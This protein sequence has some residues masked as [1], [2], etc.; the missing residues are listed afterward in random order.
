MKMETQ[1][2]LSST[3]LIILVLVG[4]LLAFPAVFAGQTNP[5]QIGLSVGLG[6]I[7]SATVALVRWAILP[8]TQKHT[9]IDGNKQIYQAF[10][11]VLSAHHGDNEPHEIFTI[12]SF[13]PEPEVGRSYDEFLTHWLG[14]NPRSR[15]VRAI[16]SQR[17]S[18]WERRFAEIESRYHRSNYHEF[19]YQGPPTVEMFLFDTETVI[20]S[21]ASQEAHEPPVS[22]ALVMKD[23]QFQRL[24]QAYHR[25]H[26]QREENRTRPSKAA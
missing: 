21:F 22:S 6:I 13:P 18:A 26:L 2:A 20:L 5:Q 19:R 17:S 11:K 4:V 14:E 25:Y 15:F 16:I 3:V 8:R 7:V 1:D 24:L 23:P 10:E 9:V 12:N